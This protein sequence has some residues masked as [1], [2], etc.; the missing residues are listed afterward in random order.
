MF[1]T[2]AIKH[3][4]SKMSENAL[5]ERGFTPI[6]NSRG[7]VRKFVYNAPKD[8][9]AP[10]LT[11]SRCP[12]NFFH[13]RAE[14]SLTAWFEKSNVRLANE[15]DL[16]CGFLRISEYA[17]AMFDTGFDAAA[18]NVVR[19][20][21]ARDFNLGNKVI[22][23]LE[24]L[25]KLNIPR[26]LRSTVGSSVYFTAG[27][28]QA[29]KRIRIYDKYAE[30]VA[31]NGSQAER[32]D[33]RGILRL[34]VAQMTTRAIDR[35]KKKLKLQ[36]RKAVDMLTPGV[37]EF[38]LSEANEHLR[39]GET[40]TSAGRTDAEQ[41]IELFGATDAEQLLGFITLRQN[42]G[43]NFYNLPGLNYSKATYF[44]R[45]KKCHSAGLKS[46]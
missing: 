28:K 8:S 2:I 21:F 44:R 17:S 31:K 1:D 23:T 35:L 15:Q 6:F 26:H 39:I 27:R 4:R 29:V 42:F 10:R 33:S 32:N 16:Q 19:A 34:E 12:Q 22:S 43:A 20:D 18:A 41:L 36:S 25:A 5:R 45:L 46:L 13:L 14:V 40:V 9:F 38:V 3:T 37:A 7:E 30:T 11:V 24:R